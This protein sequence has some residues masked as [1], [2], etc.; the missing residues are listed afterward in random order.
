MLR[1]WDMQ[2]EVAI[3]VVGAVQDLAVQEAMRE[4]MTTQRSRVIFDL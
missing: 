3:L 1:N 2:L 4:G